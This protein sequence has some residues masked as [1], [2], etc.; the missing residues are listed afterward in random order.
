MQIYWDV[1]QLRLFKNW[2]EK[3]VIEITSAVVPVDDRTFEPMIPDHALQLFG[4]K[5]RGRGW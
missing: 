1:Q 3:L 5:I 4:G 2:P